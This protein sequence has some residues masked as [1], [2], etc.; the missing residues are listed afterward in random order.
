MA[1]QDITDAQLRAFFEVIKSKPHFKVYITLQSKLNQICDQFDKLP[2]SLDEDSDIFKNF[3][4]F[5]KQARDLLVD[6]EEL[7]KHLDPTSASE[8]KKKQESAVEG[9]LEDMISKMIK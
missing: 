5:S 3:M 9:S 1:K 8:A 2:I 7:W 6:M 4:V